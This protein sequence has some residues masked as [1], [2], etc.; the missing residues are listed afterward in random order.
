MLHTGLVRQ[1]PVT[2]DRVA[3]ALD[4]T[5]IDGERRPQTLSVD[6]WLALQRALGPIE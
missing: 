3:T 4:E 2:G 1:L 6:E 5:G